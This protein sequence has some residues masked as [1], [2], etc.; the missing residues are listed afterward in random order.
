MQVCGLMRHRWR[1]PVASSAF[2]Q[3]LSVGS[4]VGLPSICPMTSDH[5]GL[6]IIPIHWLASSLPPLHLYLVCGGRSVQYGCRRIIQVDAAHWWWMRRFPPLLWKALWVLRK[7]LYKC[8]KF[9]LLSCWN[10]ALRPSLRRE[11]GYCSASVF[12]ST[13]WHSWFPQWTVAPQCRQHSC[14]PRP[15]HPHHH[16]WL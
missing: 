14:T 9:L 12:H 2:L 11:R 16:A 13:C 6:L 4:A 3:L 5:H 10:T 1:S 15:W 7:A 8:N